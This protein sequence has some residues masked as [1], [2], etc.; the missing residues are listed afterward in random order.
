VWDGG[1]DE[2]KVSNKEAGWGR[3]LWLIIDNNDSQGKSKD[4]NVFGQHLAATAVAGAAGE[5]KG[6]L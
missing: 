6:A 1:E 3:C 2:G 4:I 5:D